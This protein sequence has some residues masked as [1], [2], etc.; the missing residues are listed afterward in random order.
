[1]CSAEGG[2]KRH[3]IPCCERT[4][5]TVDE[6]GSDFTRARKSFI[7]RFAPIKLEPRSLY[8]SMGFMWSEMNLRNAAKKES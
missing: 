7:S 4:L 5:S 8:I 1:M 6:W 3:W 2:L